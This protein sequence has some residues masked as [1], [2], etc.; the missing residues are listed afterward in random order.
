MQPVQVF[1][2]SAF[3]VQLEQYGFCKRK[4]QVVLAKSKRACCQKKE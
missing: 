4:K 3:S 1:C 2:A